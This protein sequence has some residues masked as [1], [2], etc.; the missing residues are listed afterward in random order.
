MIIENSQDTIVFDLPKSY[1]NIGIKISGGADSAIVLYMLCKYI[2][3]NKIECEINPITVC[4]AG[5]AFQ[6]QYAT[7]VIF[8]M[9]KTFPG[10]R[11]GNHYTGVNYH[12]ESYAPVQEKL[13]NQCYKN[14]QIDCHFVGITKNPPKDIADGFVAQPGPQDDRSAGVFRETNLNNRVFRPLINIDKKGVKELYEHFG[15]L[16]TLFPLTR[17]CERMTDDFSKH[18]ETECWF[19]CERHW[20]FNRYE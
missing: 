2:Y 6:L 19:C 12:P 10:I 16:D 11:F 1:K 9:Q 8:F 17:S 5:K 4:H 14:K 7:K 3:D 15:V 18:C 20:G 13:V